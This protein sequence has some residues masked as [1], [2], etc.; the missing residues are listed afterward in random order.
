[1]KSNGFLIYC[2]HAN[3]FYMNVKYV[4]INNISHDLRQGYISDIII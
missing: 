1:M 4:N 2:I 3:G